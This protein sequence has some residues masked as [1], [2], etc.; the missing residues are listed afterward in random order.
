ML[1]NNP[2]K[3]GEMKDEDYDRGVITMMAK[4]YWRNLSSQVSSHESTEKMEKLNTK[5]MKA[6]RRGR[7]QTVSLSC[8]NLNTLIRYL[9]T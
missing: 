7:R 5:Q 3:K 4:S 8:Q 6:R 2:S 9:P 1:R